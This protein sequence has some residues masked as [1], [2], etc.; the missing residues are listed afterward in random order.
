MLCM[1]STATADIMKNLKTTSDMKMNDTKQKTENTLDEASACVP[2]TCYSSDR[3]CARHTTLSAA[4]LPAAAETA[5]LT[6]AVPAAAQP[7]VAETA[8]LTLPSYQVG[9]VVGNQPGGWLRENQPL[10]GWLSITNLG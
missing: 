8:A 5:A 6:A 9:Y 2:S 4:A 7:A 1:P 3:R 10:R